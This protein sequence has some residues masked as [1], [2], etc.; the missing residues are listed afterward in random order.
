MK[1]KYIKQRGGLKIQYLILIGLI[2]PFIAVSCKTTPGGTSGG[3]LSAPVDDDSMI[4]IARAR[5]AAEETRSEVEYVDGST[6]CPDEWE[7]AENR[8]SA[9]R[10]YDTPITRG[11]AL[12]Q[13][14]EWK[15]LKVDYENIYNQALPQCA[16][17]QQRLLAAARENAVNTGADKLVPERFAQADDVAESS[18]EKFKKDDFISSIREGREACDRYKVLQT[19]AAAHNQQAEADKYDFFSSDPDS[20]KLAADAGNRAV[21]LYDENRLPEA[22]EEAEDALNRFLQVVQNGWGYKVE[23]K[24]SYA[25]KWRAASL[26]V[27]ADVASKPEFDAAEQVYNRARAVQTSENYIRAAELFDESGKLFIIA[28]DDAVEKQERADAALR[29]AERRLTESKSKAQAAEDLIGGE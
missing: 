23:E 5:T 11:D 18:R 21:D 24:S 22:Q 28:H 20:Y 7:L 27:K 29:E 2:F 14:E 10:K 15:A 16:A 17:E 26:D 8:Y 6:Y 12:T 13:V 3:G 19:I 25:R 1:E 9:A 4:A